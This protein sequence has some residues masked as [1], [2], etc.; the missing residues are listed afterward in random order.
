MALWQIILLAAWSICVLAHPMETMGFSSN[1][2]PPQTTDI[3]ANPRIT[4]S[5]PSQLELT[6]SDK[7]HQPMFPL[8]EHTKGHT[9]RL[10][11]FIHDLVLAMQ[12]LDQNHH[13]TL[14]EKL[15]PEAIYQKLRDGSSP[16]QRA[17]IEQFYE[18]FRTKYE[19]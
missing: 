2:E 1:E 17:L 19:Y 7:E 16:E 6:Q 10:R 15:A 13:A 14:A 8:D 5:D 12:D 9:R 3:L 11:Q 4:E 18:E